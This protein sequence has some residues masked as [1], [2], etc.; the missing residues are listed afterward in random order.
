MASKR[1]TQRQPADGLAMMEDQESVRRAMIEIPELRRGYSVSLSQRRYLASDLPPLHTLAD[2]FADMAS[3]ALKM[4]FASVLSRLGSRSLRVA[5]MCSGTEAPLLALEMIQTGKFVNC[6]LFNSLARCLLMLS[7]SIAFSPN[8]GGQIG[9]RLTSHIACLFGYLILSDI[10]ISFNP[11]FI[12]FGLRRKKRKR[13][14]AN[15]LAG[16]GMDQQLRI[17]HAFSCEIV[18]LKQSYI[19]RNFRPPLLFRDITELGGEKA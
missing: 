9:L 8:S 5:T 18:P 19:E 10:D 17:S 1:E 4:G 12:L 15:I 7:C 16:L 3:N 14:I 11:C 2:I 6:F 13:A